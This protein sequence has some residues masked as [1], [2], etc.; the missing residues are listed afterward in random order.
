MLSL[1][2]RDASPLLPSRRRPCGEPRNESYPLAHGTLLLGR[3]QVCEVVGEGAYSVVYRAVDTTSGRQVAI[4]CLW[5]ELTGDDFR[6]RIEREGRLLADIHNAHVATLRGTGK[7]ASGAP[8]L[9]LEYLD[10]VDLGARLLS[11][12]ALQPPEAVQIALQ[13]CE[14]LAAVHALGIIHQDLCP[15]NAFLL[16]NE[17]APR[18]KLVDFGAAR[19]VSALHPSD[20]GND[21]AAVEYGTPMYLAPESLERTTTVGS[22]ADVYSLGLLIYE[23]LKGTAALWKNFGDLSQRRSDHVRGRPRHT[24]DTTGIPRELWAVLEQA[25]SPVPGSRFTDTTEFSIA[26]CAGR[27]GG[28]AMPRP[29]ISRPST[30]GAGSALGP[31]Q[32]QVQSLRARARIL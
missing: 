19:S 6:A 16:G 7:L 22:C 12:G 24:V 4:K 11:R 29:A 9:L 27:Q 20:G 26:L 31:R 15:G 1:D 3:Y 8:F 2:H 10:G 18:T 23:M 28:A 30:H 25:L 5:N 32:S 17:F 13:I 21:R 14:G